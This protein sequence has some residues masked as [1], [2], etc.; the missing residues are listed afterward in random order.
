VPVTEIVDVVSPFGYHVYD[1]PLDALNVTLPPG[2]NAI[3]VS[4]NILISGAAKTET[5]IMEDVPVQPV[6]LSTVTKYDPLVIAEMVFPVP[7]V[8]HK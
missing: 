1:D 8:F 2:G 7:P 5:S 3:G 4:N 6:P